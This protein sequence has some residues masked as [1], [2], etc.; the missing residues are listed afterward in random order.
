MKTLLAT[1]FAVS[2]FVAPAAAR[3]ADPAHGQMP[4]EYAEEFQGYVPGADRLEGRILA[5]CCWNQTLDIH[6][7]EISNG[8]KR[9]IRQRLRRGDTPDTIE[10]DL[11]HRYGERV[12][13]VPKHSP[14]KGVAIALAAGMGLAGAGA[15]AMLVRWRRRAAQSAPNKPATMK[16]TAEPARDELDDRLDRELEAD[17]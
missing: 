6:G 11:V 14:L 13:A 7:S 1:A 2:V 8:L 17:D 15:V 10:A 9:E 3:A 16:S 5:P 12:L 4:A